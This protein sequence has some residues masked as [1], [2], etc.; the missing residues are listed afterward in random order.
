[1]IFCAAGCAAG[2]AVDCAARFPLPGSRDA[3]FLFFRSSIF[4]AIST[5]DQA[6]ARTLSCAAGFQVV[7]ICTGTGDKKLF[8]IDQRFE[9]GPIS[10]SLQKKRRCLSVPFRRQF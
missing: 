3:R 4:F 2:C 6:V 9:M 8:E 7:S 10:S 5:V 1:V